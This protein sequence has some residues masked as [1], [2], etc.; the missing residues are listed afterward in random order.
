MQGDKEASLPTC[1][2]VLGNKKKNQLG[3]RSSSNL[4][5]EKKMALP[6]REKK[7][8]AFQE[9]FRLRNL[10]YIVSLTIPPKRKIAI[11]YLTIITWPE[12]QQKTS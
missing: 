2:D 11:N 7:N 1:G 3:P 6:Q 12:T 9:S 4:S 8:T 5:Y 10:K